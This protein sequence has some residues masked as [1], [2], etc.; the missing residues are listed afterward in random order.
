[1]YH[2]SYC[3]NYTSEALIY[4]QKVCRPIEQNS[5]IRNE[6]NKMYSRYTLEKD[7]IFNKGIWEM[8]ISIDGRMKLGPTCC[9]SEIPIQDKISE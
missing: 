8:W 3:L 7:S 2:N 4:I 6:P 5:G 1:M 9:L